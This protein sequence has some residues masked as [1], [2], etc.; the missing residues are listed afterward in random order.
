MEGRDG[1]P[2][3]IRPEAVLHSTTAG[4]VVVDRS[5]RLVFVNDAAAA[6]A[7]VSREELVGQPFDHSVWNARHRSGRRLRRDESPI[8]RA[9]AGEAEATGELVVDTPNG[10]TVVMLASARPVLDDR[11]VVDAVVAT[12]Q[13]VTEAVGREMRLRT[14]Q[15]RLAAVF[16]H[17]SDA[18]VLVD[19]RRRHVAA[20]PATAAMLG[21]SRSELLR[22]SMDDVVA[23]PVDPGTVFEEFLARGT[24]RRELELRRA[25]GTLITVEAVAVA[26]VEPGVHLSIWRDLSETRRM[27]RRVE[28]MQQRL[29]TVVAGSSI[30]LLL[31][32]PTGTIVLAN[33]AARSILRAPDAEGRH[34]VDVLVTQLPDLPDGLVSSGGTTGGEVLLP[35]HD[36]RWLTFRVSTLDTAGERLVHVEDATSS[37]AG[38]QAL[39]AALAREHQAMED[40]VE[41]DRMKDAFM[42]AV[43][44]E[45]RT[46]LTTIRGLAETVQRHGDRLDPEQRADFLD[47]LLHHTD[48]LEGLLSDL[49]S[50]DRLRRGV[51]MVDVG[52]AH[53]R[54]LLEATVAGLDADGHHLSVDAPDDVVWVDRA[55]VERMV[56]NLVVNAVRHTP[57]GSRVEI[58]A[59]STDGHVVIEVEDDGAG[60]PAEVRDS[61]FE[62]FAKGTTGRARAEGTGVGLA[63]VREFAT[64]MGGTAMLCEGRLGGTLLRLVLPDD[65]RD[66]LAPAE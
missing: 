50:I 18:V 38:E 9:L 44:H 47:R 53:L 43:S 4:L 19:D 1:A 20:N 65:P 31:V 40:L 21:Y 39:R 13:D 55:K 33:P 61:V 32:E 54:S 42:S 25:D 23:P 34:L 63:L 2:Q 30:G 46:P 35:T 22:L 28:L 57:R 11:G 8:D 26:N 56:E 17:A 52:P 64:L 59:R 3:G 37:V 5:G 15:A 45:L 16:E 60:I 7:G 48:R 51:G 24:D 36:G 27:L 66:R 58:R 6:I 12:I 62:M 29:A 41:V 14:E 49:L 10:G